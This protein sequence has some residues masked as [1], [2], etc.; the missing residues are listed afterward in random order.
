VELDDALGQCHLDVDT[1]DYRRRTRRVSELL[2]DD[3]Q[4]CSASNRATQW[5]KLSTQHQQSAS[6][7]CKLTGSDYQYKS[8]MEHRKCR[9]RK[10]GTKNAFSGPS[11]SNPALLVLHFPVLHFLVMH[12]QST[13]NSQRT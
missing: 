10:C 12:Y 2:S 6:Y 8:T 3:R 5:L 11:F 7:A 13:L 9:T 4:R 1:V